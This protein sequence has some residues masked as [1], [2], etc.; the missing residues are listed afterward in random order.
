MADVRSKLEE[1]EMQRDMARVEKELSAL[2]A[3]IDGSFSG[4]DSADKRDTNIGFRV[5]VE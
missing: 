4:D 2:G 5:V 1:L 3:N